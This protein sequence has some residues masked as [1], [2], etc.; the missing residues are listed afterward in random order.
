MK[1]EPDTRQV[2]QDYMHENAPKKLN[3]NFYWDRA[4]GLVELIIT[5]PEYQLA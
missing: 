2:L 5:S 1:L 4:S 3:P